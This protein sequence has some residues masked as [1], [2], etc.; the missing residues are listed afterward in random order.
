MRL[1][2]CFA[3]SEQ[4]QRSLPLLSHLTQ[5]EGFTEKGTENYGFVFQAYSNTRIDYTST[6]CGNLAC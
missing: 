3:C 4:V 5:I 1:S 6:K 2:D